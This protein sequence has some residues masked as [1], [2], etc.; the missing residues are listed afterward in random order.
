LKHSK[1]GGFGL[2][3]IVTRKANLSDLVAIKQLAD[4]EK[5]S[6]GFITRQTIMEAIANSSIMLIVVNGKIV[7][8]Q[9]YYHRKRDLQTTLYH[10]TIDKEFRGHGLGRILVNSVIEEA[11]LLGRKKLFLKCPIDLPSNHFHKAIGFVLV[12]KEQGKKRELNLWE[13]SI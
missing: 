13:Y 9:H 12:G 3:N 4:K 11:R 6:L 10:K 2:K 5:S 8:F 1:K 7:G